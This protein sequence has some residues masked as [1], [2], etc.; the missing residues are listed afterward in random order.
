MQKVG[1]KIRP[2]V[3]L[4]VWKVLVSSH[5][6]RVRASAEIPLPLGTWRAEL[7]LVIHTSFLICI[8]FSATVLSR[9]HPTLGLCAY[10]PPGSQFLLRSVSRRMPGLTVTSFETG[11]L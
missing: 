3:N 8:L 6:P 5:S 4:L 11:L 10:C 2:D 9:Q 7:E 1:E